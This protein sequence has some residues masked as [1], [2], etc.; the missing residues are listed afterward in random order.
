MDMGGHDVVK[1]SSYGAQ[2]LTV[3]ES[4]KD[5]MPMC[6]LRQIVEAAQRTTNPRRTPITWPIPMTNKPLINA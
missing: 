5:P 6:N 2:L 3:D 1:V 4:M